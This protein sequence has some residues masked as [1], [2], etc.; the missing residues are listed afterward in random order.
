MIAQIVS[1]IGKIFVFRVTG[2]VR[3][4]REILRISNKIQ[5]QLHTWFLS[6]N[7]MLHKN[8]SIIAPFT[9]VDLSLPTT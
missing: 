5:H 7:V 2:H 4:H 8:P 1:Q 9:H 6:K 3:P